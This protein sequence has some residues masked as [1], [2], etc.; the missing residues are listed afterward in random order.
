M[1]QQHLFKQVIFIQA[2]QQVR[3]EA[4]QKKALGNALANAYRSNGKRRI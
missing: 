2:M 1:S 3:R 4:E